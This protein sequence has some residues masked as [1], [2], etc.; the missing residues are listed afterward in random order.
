MQFAMHVMHSIATQN[1]RSESFSGRAFLCS[2]LPFV[3]RA[4]C[5]FIEQPEKLNRRGPRVCEL[6]SRSERLQFAM[7]VLCSIV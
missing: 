7:H 5:H 4:R 6:M 1:S 3:V 2:S